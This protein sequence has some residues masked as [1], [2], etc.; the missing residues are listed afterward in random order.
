MQQKVLVSSEASVQMNSAPLI[1][2]LLTP[3]SGVDDVKLSDLAKYIREGKIV[4][5]QKTILYRGKKGL[6]ICLYEG[7]K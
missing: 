3:E 1:T 7:G 5:R 2:I 4:L 6:E